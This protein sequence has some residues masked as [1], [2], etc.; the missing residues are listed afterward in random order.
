MR[1]E[2]SRDVGYYI[3]GKTSNFVISRCGFTEE[4][5]EVCRLRCVTHVP[6]SCTAPSQAIPIETLSCFIVQT[7]K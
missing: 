7:Q 6:S 2:K 5:G 1:E 3:L 4:G